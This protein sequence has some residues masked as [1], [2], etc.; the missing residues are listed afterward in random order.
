MIQNLEAGSEAMIATIAKLVLKIWMFI[1]LTKF[2]DDCGV[3]TKILSTVPWAKRETQALLTGSGCIADL[4]VMFTI[5]SHD[6]STPGPV[7][8]TGRLMDCCGWIGREARQR[9]D[10]ELRI[11]VRAYFPFLVLLS[12]SLRPCYLQL[13]C[14][15]CAQ[16]CTET[17]RSPRLVTMSLPAL[18]GEST[19]SHI[20][21]S[22]P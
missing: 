20:L 22:F 2:T 14:Q 18:R 1:G 15:G 3:H 16:L 13:I 4:W 6:F 19:L 12:C 17:G 8:R 7:P 21:W 9:S 11:L 10:E 5:C